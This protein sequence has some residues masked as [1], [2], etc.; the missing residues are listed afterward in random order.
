[1]VAAAAALWG[2]V[3]LAFLAHVL[4][5]PPVARIAAALFAV[6][7]LDVGLSDLGASERTG[8]SHAFS[9]CAVWVMPGA[10]GALLVALLVRAWRES[11]RGSGRRRA[12]RLSASR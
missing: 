5:R 1:M 6:Q 3:A 2:L 10:V 8:V 11:G 12:S 4:R 9:I 7:L